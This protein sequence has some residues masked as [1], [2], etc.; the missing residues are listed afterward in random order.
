MELSSTYVVSLAKRILPVVVGAV[1]G[2]AYYYFIGCTGGTC[3]ITSNPW[4]STSY[5]AMM[6]LIFGLGN[7]KRRTN[8]DQETQKDEQ[9]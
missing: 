4:T 2:F 5:G 9:K 8:H 3:P 7:S 1:G 6:G